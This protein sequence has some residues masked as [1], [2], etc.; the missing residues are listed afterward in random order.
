VKEIQ[1]LD[2]NTKEGLLKAIKEKD[3][4]LKITQDLL[5]EKTETCA[6]LETENNLLRRPAEEVRTMPQKLEPNPPIMERITEKKETIT[7]KFI[8]QQ[9][10][11]SSATPLKTPSDLVLCPKLSPPDYVSVDDACKKCDGIAECPQ[12]G[13][14]V[15]LRAI[16]K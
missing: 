14:Y 9:P 1:D 2:E 7:E 8:S 13:E 15:Y 16:K 6:R 4:N 11:Q 3:M 5:R 12:Y 10:V